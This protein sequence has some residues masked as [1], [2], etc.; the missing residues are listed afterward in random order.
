MILFLIEVLF[1]LGF[2]SAPVITKDRDFKNLIVGPVNVH[3]RVGELRFLFNNLF[4]SFMEN[5]S[6]APDSGTPICLHPVLPK[7]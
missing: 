3:S 4:A 1:T 2:I 5:L 6:A 7:S